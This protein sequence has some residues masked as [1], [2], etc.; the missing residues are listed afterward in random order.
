MAP[1]TQSIDFDRTFLTLDQALSRPFDN[2]INDAEY[3]DSEALSAAIRRVGLDDDDD[4]EEEDDFDEDAE[5]DEEDDEDEEDD[6]DFEDD[7]DEED[8]DLDDDENDE[9]ENDDD[10]KLI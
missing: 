3:G 1:D 9:D 2:T 10:I 8:D 6:D 7:E 4:E 5:D